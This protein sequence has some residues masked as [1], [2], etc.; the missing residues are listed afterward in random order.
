MVEAVGLAQALTMTTQATTPTPEPPVSRRLT[1]SSDDRVI[2]GVAGGLGR[3]F[4]VD[5]VV[6]RIILVVLMFFGGA[7]FVA[8]AAAWL[9]V[10]SDK[11]PNARFGGRDIVRRTAIA[12][13]VLAATI[14]VSVGGAWGVAVGGGTATALII[15]GAGLVLVVGAVTGG[16]R[17]LIVPALALALSASAVAAADIDTRGGTGE[18]TYK[19]ASSNDLRSE[20]KLGLGHLVLDLRNTDLTPGD[21]RVHLKLGVGGAE[22]WVPDG[23]CVSSTA[24]VSAGAT[25]IFGHETGGADHE[26]QDTQKAAPD[27]PHLI[28]DGDIGVGALRIQQGPGQSSTGNQACARG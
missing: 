14:I 8:Y 13:G 20:Y 5:P 6:I 18:R 16:M 22:V 19:P 25:V 28:V 17:W 3:Y 24:H 9:F 23:V 12:L 27:T 4:G 2:A 26:W 21:H 11:D 10:P 7:G 15:I 1:R